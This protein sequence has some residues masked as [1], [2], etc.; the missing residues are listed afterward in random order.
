[1][2]DTHCH[3]VYG[4]DDG[5]SCA[6]ESLEMARIAVASGITDIIA[7]PHS[8]PGM[9]ENYAGRAYDEAF[10]RL[11]DLL[12]SD[13]MTAR[14]RIHKGMEAF[15]DPETI[16]RFNSGMMHCMGNSD[17]LLIECDFG[18]DPWFLREV[19]KQ[20]QRRNVRV[21]IAHPERYYFAHDNI[22]YLFDLTEMGCI[23]QL[24]TESITGSFGSDCREAAMILLD[25]GIAQ[26]AGSD[27]HDADERTPDMR[28]AADIVANRFSLDYA[29]LIFDENPARMLRNESL[30]FRRRSSSRGSRDGRFMSDD[31]YWGE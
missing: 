20:L 19:I 13:P 8:I 14:L 30:L 3:I 9:F 4:I 7:T 27:A 18:E 11:N 26:L 5:S 1:M 2:I 12:R 31:E 15:A 24:D 25:A 22:R 29:R 17:Y 10:E 28:Q 16:E 6:E 21:I 23:M